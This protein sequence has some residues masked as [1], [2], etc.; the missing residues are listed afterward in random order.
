MDAGVDPGRYILGDDLT[1]LDVA[2][3]VMSR[4]TPRRRRFYEVAPKMTEV[5]RRVDAEPRL[6]ALWAA[7]FP[8]EDG[9]EG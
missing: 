7:R 9:W 2:V 8:F 3:T 1:V 4:W 5:V 6:Q